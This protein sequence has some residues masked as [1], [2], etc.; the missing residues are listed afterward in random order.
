M[1]LKKLQY[2]FSVCKVT[3]LD[4]MDLDN[5][6]G[7]LAVSTYNTDYMLVKKE[8]FEKALDVLQ[9]AGYLIV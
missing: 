4:G 1:E 3:P 5:K 9:K 7:I 2:D 6:I 8:N